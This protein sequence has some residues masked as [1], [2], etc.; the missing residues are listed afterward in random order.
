MRPR[1]LS[2]RVARLDTRDPP[3][4]W[5]SEDSAPPSVPATGGPLVIGAA[6]VKHW[7]PVPIEDGTTRSR[8]REVFFLLLPRHRRRPD[9][10]RAHDRA[11]VESIASKFSCSHRVAD[12]FADQCEERICDLDFDLIYSKLALDFWADPPEA[13]RPV[14]EAL[15]EL[16][17]EHQRYMVALGQLRE[18]LLELT[19][20]IAYGTLT[21]A[22]RARR[23]AV[24]TA[25]PTI[26]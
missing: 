20:E 3:C 22:E 10:G 17:A 12:D 18:R 14:V 24:R 1:R 16:E 4:F 19:R 26:C 9:P 23:H 7:L 21:K 13:A 6:S 5:S 15:R 2:V 25:S 8:D 11:V